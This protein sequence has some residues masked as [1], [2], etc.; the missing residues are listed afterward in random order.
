MQFNYICNATVLLMHAFYTLPPT[1]FKYNIIFYSYTETCTRCSKLNSYLKIILHFV[2]QENIL[3][4]I[5]CYCVYVITH[6]NVADI[7]H[8]HSIKVFMVGVSSRDSHQVSMETNDS[9]VPP[10]SYTHL[11]VYKRQYIDSENRSPWIL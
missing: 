3:Q 2:L 9:R 11:D 7:S 5:S 6:Y 8:C 10:V 4:K 1:L